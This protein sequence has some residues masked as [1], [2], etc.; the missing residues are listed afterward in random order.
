M[1]IFNVS[2]DCKK[3]Y[4]Y[5]RLVGPKAAQKCR[6]PYVDPAEKVVENVEKEEIPAQ[7]RALLDIPRL[8]V[9]RAKLA[10]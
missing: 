1:Q 2:F 5:G 6:K 3:R 7:A 10:P 4:P 9:P 8:R